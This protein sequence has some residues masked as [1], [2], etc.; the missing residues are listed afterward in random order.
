MRFVLTE[1]FL[2]RKQRSVFVQFRLQIQSHFFSGALM[3]VLIL[4]AC[5]AAPKIMSSPTSDEVRWNCQTQT[6]AI[7][8]TACELH[9][10]HISRCWVV[11]AWSAS[12]FLLFPAFSSS[13]FQS[14]CLNSQKSQKVCVGHA[15]Q[16]VI[17]GGYCSRHRYLGNALLFA[18]GLPSSVVTSTHSRELVSWH[19]WCRSQIR[20]SGR[21]TDGHQRRR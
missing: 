8:V 10:T 17:D 16:G 7:F 20:P 19:K 4:Q 13:A 9:L 18:L 15:C 21:R 14:W 6:S 11:W 2:L 12:R 5:Q 1:F 3:L